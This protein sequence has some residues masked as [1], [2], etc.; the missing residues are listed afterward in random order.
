MANIGK[1]ATSLQKEQ[2]ISFRAGEIVGLIY[3][4]FLKQYGPKPTEAEL[5]SL[6]VLCVRLVFC[7]Y[8]EDAGIFEKN[9]FYNYMSEYKPEQMRKALIE[10]F[11][12]LN[13]PVCER[14]RFLAESL[15]NF[16]YANGAL[17]DIKQNE[18]IPKINEEIADVLLKKASLG[19]DWS[20]ISPTIFGAVFESTLNS[21]TLARLDGKLIIQPELSS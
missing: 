9:Q 8:A 7:L 18:S 3:D 19:F 5:H 16:P 15:K 1:S 4:A 12:T 17:F 21:E 14:D 6:N 11:R 13:T 20:G 2:D 10:L